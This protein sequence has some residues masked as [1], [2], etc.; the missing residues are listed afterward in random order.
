MRKGAEA[1]FYILSHSKPAEDTEMG[2]VRSAARYF[3][4]LYSEGTIIFK[5]SFDGRFVE[6]GC[7]LFQGMFQ[8]AHGVLSAFSVLHLSGPSALSWTPR[9][10]SGERRG[11]GPGGQRRR[12][13]GRGQGEPALRGDAGGAPRARARPS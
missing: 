7:S 5:R 2:T 12:V 11:G 8:A 13:G 1:N 4:K 9:P 10:P 6:F 3:S